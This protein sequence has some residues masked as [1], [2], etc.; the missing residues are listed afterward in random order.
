MLGVVLSTHGGSGTLLGFFIGLSNAMMFL[1]HFILLYAPFGLFFATAAYVVQTRNLQPLASHLALYVFAVALSLVV[2]ALVVLPFVLATATG[3]S[4]RG[5]LQNAATP[6]AVAFG[7][8]SSS[9][10]V[11]PTIAALEERLNLD[12]RIVRLLVPIAAVLNT[13]GTSIY[14]TISALF[15]A[16]TKTDYVDLR[17]VVLVCMAAPTTGGPSYLRLRLIHEAVGMPTDTIGIL[18]ITDWIVSR[19]ANVVDVLTGLVSVYV[20]QHY[21][22]LE[23]QPTVEDANRDIPP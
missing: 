8:A 12:T 11:P 23:E 14:I 2:H 21:C 13:D 19:L 17:T 15:F 10:T 3:R 9:E 5:L 22:G 18:F 1:A 4:F 16:Q 20:V 7:A 6:L